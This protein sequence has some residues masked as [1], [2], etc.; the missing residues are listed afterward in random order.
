MAALTSA[1]AASSSSINWKKTYPSAAAEAKASNKLIMIDFYTGWCGWCK[2]LDADTYPSAEV[3]KASDKFVSIKLDAEKDSD[4][5]RLAKKFGI[6]GYPTILFLDSKENL[7]YKV[8]GY[9]GPKEFSA[10]M[11]KAGNIRAEIA[12]F[13]KAIQANPADGDALA[14]LASAEASQGRLDKAS[15][16][17]AAAES[18]KVTHKEILLDAYNAVGDGYQNAGKFDQAISVFKKAISQ[19]FEK[20]S[21][22]ARISIAICF[23]TS[24]R[25][26]D[27]K[28]FLEDLIK[29]K[30]A[31]KEYVN[32]A[33]QMLKAIN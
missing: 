31:P 17:L 33:N 3:V 29:Q 9:L 19:G 23:A 7:Q 1:F 4:G 27:A 18:A 21:A 5:V 14:G 8:V 20:Q 24:N 6:T 28:P 30:E 22:Y 25:L 32:Q 12:K 13:Q 16:D 10:E 15:A 2:K 26:A 11:N